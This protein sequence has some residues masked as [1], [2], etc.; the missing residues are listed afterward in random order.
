MPYVGNGNVS[1]MQKFINSGP[2]D[3]EEI[4][5]DLQHVF[6]KELVPTAAGSPIGVVGVVDE[7]AFTKK[8]D[9]SEESPVN[10][11]D[12]W[13]RKTTARSGSFSR[14]SLPG[15][16]A[17]ALSPDP[18]EQWCEQTQESK[19]RRKRGPCAPWIDLLRRKLTDCCGSDPDSRS[20][21]HGPAG[22]G[23]RRRAQQAERPIPQR[24]QAS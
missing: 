5:A 2:W 17:C 11:T 21:R 10:T 9:K 6:A 8:G 15:W 4:E 16:L 3:H 14:Q 23:H 13:A 20:S 7:S 1:A 19:D 12:A 18:P 22:L 24:V